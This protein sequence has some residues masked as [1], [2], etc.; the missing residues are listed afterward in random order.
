MEKQSIVIF[1]CPQSPVLT[2]HPDASLTGQTTTESLNKQLKNLTWKHGDQDIYLY[3]FLGRNRMTA[4]KNDVKYS[5][6]RFIKL[7]FYCLVWSIFTKFIIRCSITGNET[8]ASPCIGSDIKVVCPAFCRNF[9]E[10]FICRLQRVGDWRDALYMWDGA[11]SLWR[12]MP[13][14]LVVFVNGFVCCLVG[15]KPLCLS[16]ASVFVGLGC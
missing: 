10:Y 1:P 5:A 16:L 11:V 14:G 7:W 12:W 3:A 4:S 6:R 13:C 8:G 15:S 9:L 2:Q